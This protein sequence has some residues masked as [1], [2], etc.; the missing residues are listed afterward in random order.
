MM[1]KTKY[2]KL[3]MVL[4]PGTI[5]FAQQ[6]PNQ[7]NLEAGS[8]LYSGTS[9]PFWLFS[10][11]YSLFEH[12]ANN[13]Y[14]RT[15]YNRYFREDKKIDFS[16]GFNLVN[17]FSSDY[18]AYFEEGYGKVKL[19]FV[20]LQA[21]RIKESFGNQDSTLS[22]GGLL[23]SGNSLPIPAVSLSTPEYVPIPLSHGY[24]HFKAGISHGW[25]E[26]NLYVK[27]ALLHHKYLFFKA[28]GDLPVNFSIGLHH[29]SQWGGTSTNPL[30]GS[31]P[32]DLRAFRN[33]FFA[34]SG[35]S[36]SPVNDQKNAA[37]N[38]LGSYNL[39]AD[40]KLN[41]F[42][43][44]L[45]WQSIF[46][47]NSGRTNRNLW[48]GLYGI[49]VTMNKTKILSRILLEM[50]STT[51]QSGA[52]Q[53]PDPSDPRPPTWN[54]NYFNNW[55]YKMGWSYQNMTIGN[56]LFT[57]PILTDENKETENFNNNRVNAIHT[58][59]NGKI[60][61]IEYILFYTYSVNKGTYQFEYNPS[62]N[63]SS[64]MLKLTYQGLL[65]ETDI[66]FILGIDKGE[67]YGNNIG[68]EMNYVKRISF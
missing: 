47:D 57:S 56:P 61:V 13:F 7:I 32:S 63:Q 64:L 66:S 21:G 23:W 29:F 59:L 49:S 25:F 18:S 46:E 15:G 43:I 41:P 28:G 30:Y 44:G 17:R 20:Q 62:K 52:P 11:Q 48:D 42:N 31:L 37:G 33:V 24:L 35:E 5:I 40:I 26:N 34:R 65:K 27:N 58:G 53:L 14:I 60:S 54:D 2:V 22:S 55:L 16:W 68:I 3:L 51:Y 10:N 50:L 67:M 12:N 19:Y 9:L 8:L 1:K 36:D 6:T 45:Y 4:F 39:R 38:H